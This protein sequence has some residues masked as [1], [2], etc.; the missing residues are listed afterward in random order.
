MRADEFDLVVVGAGG[1]GLVAAL[2]AAQLGARVALLEKTDRPGGGTALSS[3]SLQAGGTVYQQRQGIEDSPALYARDIATRNNGRGDAVLAERLTENAP[4]LVEWLAETLG[5]DLRV[6]DFPF[7]HS[8]PRSHTWTADKPLTDLLFDAVQR[9]PRIQ[10]YFGVAAAAFAVDAAGAV[11][12]VVTDQGTFRG[13]RV[14]LATGGFG[15]SQDLLARYIPKAVGIPFP[16]HAGSTGDGLQMALALSAATAHL[17]AFQPYPAHIGPG[18]R[19]VSP[20]VILAGGIMVGA[21]GKRFVDE[22]RYPGGLSAGIL[23]QPDKHAYEIFDQRILDLHR[24]LLETRS[25]LAALTREGLFVEGATAADL[26]AKLGIDAAGLAETIRAYNAALGGRDAFGRA[27]KAALGTPLYGIRVTVALYHTQ[28][29]IRVNPDGQVLRAD[30]S[31]I[32][33]LY[34]GGGVAAGVSGDGMDGY[35]PGNGQ[36]ASLG[37]GYVAAGHAVASLRAPAGQP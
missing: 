33:N 1:C 23:D 3:Q 11:T 13:R 35:L 34:A 27:V 32:P 31:P 26:A 5:L 29:G 6:P 37:L 2:R 19:A 28:G 10:P 18:K 4:A 12:G 21:D 8:A 15:A 16:G 25:Q 24:N 14:L 22:T 9:E 36:L 17:D 20:D 30:G 7:G